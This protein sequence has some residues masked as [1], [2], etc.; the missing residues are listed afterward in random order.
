MSGI[1]FLTFVARTATIGAVIFLATSMANYN[2]GFCEYRRHEI[3]SASLFLIGAILFVAVGREWY[4]QLFATL[5]SIAFFIGRMRISDFLWLS[6]NK[7]FRRWL[8]QRKKYQK[9]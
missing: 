8:K 7:G 3:V 6:R 9:N 4:S 5:L 1:E 2:R